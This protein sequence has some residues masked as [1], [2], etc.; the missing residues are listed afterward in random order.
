MH[1]RCRKTKTDG[2]HKTFLTLFVS[3]REE[4]L[5]ASLDD[6]FY[7]FTQ[8]TNQTKNTT[9]GRGG[10]RD[11][12]QC[13]ASGIRRG[14]PKSVPQKVSEDVTTALFLFIS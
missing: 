1:I 8:K 13:G 7:V 11:V 12:S 5:V 2:R 6:V 10:D 9:G 4:R 3:L 14:C